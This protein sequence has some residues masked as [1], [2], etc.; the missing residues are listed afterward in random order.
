MGVS[1]II[2]DTCFLKIKI[3]LNFYWYF[4]KPKNYKSGGKAELTFLIFFSIL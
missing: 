3:I 2:I 1:P 4:L